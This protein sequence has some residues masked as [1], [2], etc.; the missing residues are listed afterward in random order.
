VVLGDRRELCCPWS[1]GPP[2]ATGPAA[3]RDLIA[4]GKSVTEAARILKIGRSTAYAALA[5]F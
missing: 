2:P 1:G 4:G 5:A 3:L